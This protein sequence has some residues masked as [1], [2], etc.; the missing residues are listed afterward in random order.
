MKT[1]VARQANRLADLGTN[2]VIDRLCGKAAARG[3]A[4]SIVAGTYTYRSVSSALWFISLN[5]IS[6]ILTAHIIVIFTIHNLR[7]IHKSLSPIYRFISDRTDGEDQG[8]G[9]YWPAATFDLCSLRDQGWGR[10]TCYITWWTLLCLR[11]LHLRVPYT[12]TFV[13]E[14]NVCNDIYC[15]NIIEVVH[16]PYLFQWHFL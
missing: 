1:F 15:C 3:L 8:Y 11:N 12:V 13:R 2:G 4:F 16:F 5:S 9:S 6:L 14:F 7:L 10:H